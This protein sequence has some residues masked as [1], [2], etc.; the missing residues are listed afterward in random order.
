MENTK[1][2]I[3]DSQILAYLNVE[4]DLMD[5]QVK[6]HQNIFQKDSQTLRKIEVLE[7][8][9]NLIDRIRKVGTCLISL[10]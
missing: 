3:K 9:R 4:Y 8:Q 2:N 7:E 5:K 1:E 10:E 6:E